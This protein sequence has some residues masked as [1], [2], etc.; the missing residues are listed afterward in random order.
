MTACQISAGWSLDGS[1]VGPWPC[2][3]A[4]L[5]NGQSGG[6]RNKIGFCW[7]WHFGDLSW[8]WVLPLCALKVLLH[9]LR[10]ISCFITS[11]W[12]RIGYFSI[13]STRVLCV[14]GS[15]VVMLGVCLCFC[16]SWVMF[17]GICAECLYRR[18]YADSMNWV[19]CRRCLWL[20]MFFAWCRSSCIIFPCFSHSSAHF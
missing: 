3:V 9:V 16:R 12:G 2:H 6:Q 14:I 8:W 19:V 11:R 10:C 17:L 20:G 7:A 13:I 5:T 1:S 18:G 15:I 4:M